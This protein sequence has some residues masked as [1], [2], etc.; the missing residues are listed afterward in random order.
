MLRVKRFSKV[1]D[2]VKEIGKS[3]EH[4]VTHPKETGK[5]VV[6]YV[7]KHPDE[8]IV[9]GASD[10]VPGIVAAKL[11]KAGK[12][13]QAAIAGTIAALPIGGAYVLGKIAIR[14]WNEKRKKNK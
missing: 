12:T 6:E 11:A 13:K 8:A 9:L 5:K 7:K 10:I 14:K 2:K 1:T 4:T 3:I